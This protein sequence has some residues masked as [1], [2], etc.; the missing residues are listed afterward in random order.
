MEM[1]DYEIYVRLKGLRT[2]ARDSEVS[3]VIVT[4]GTK[5]FLHWKTPFL[6]KLT[7]SPLEFNLAKQRISLENN[8]MFQ[9]ESLFGAVGHQREDIVAC[10]DVAVLCSEFSKDRLD[11]LQLV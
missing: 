3:E 6:S 8:R 2:R 9:G 4:Q 1:A 7:G 10:L 11:T 5:S